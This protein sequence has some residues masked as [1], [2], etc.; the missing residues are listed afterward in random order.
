MALA[1]KEEIVK[2]LSIVSF[3]AIDGA[4]LSRAVPRVLCLG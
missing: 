1:C 3:T 4:R 2:A